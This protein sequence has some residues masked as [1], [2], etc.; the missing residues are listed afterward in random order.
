[1][2]IDRRPPS[3]RVVT[4]VMEIDGYE[5]CGVLL[6]IHGER[7]VARAAIFHDPLLGEMTLSPR[8]CD[9]PPID[10]TVFEL[11]LDELLAL[12]VRLG[13]AS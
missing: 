8:D 6:A 5:P 9:A 1:M 10:D 4:I 3:L 7:V 12:R 11:I 13:T 2:K